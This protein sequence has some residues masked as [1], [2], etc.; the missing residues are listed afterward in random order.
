[1]KLVPLSKEPKAVHILFELLKERKPEQSINFKMP[2][3]EQHEAYVKNRAKTHKCW[4]LLTVDDCGRK[5]Y[6][7]SVYLTKAREVG[8]FVF[9]VFRGQG[10]ASQ[11]IT[12]MLK[13]WPGKATANINPDNY[14]SIKLFES[15]GFELHQMT[16]AKT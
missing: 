1:M 13:H 10:Y 12:M 3:F 2:T 16:Y 9:E 7:G 14:P 6:V 15:L 8:V 11:G 5:I 4:Y